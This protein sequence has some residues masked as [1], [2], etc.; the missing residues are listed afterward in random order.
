MK[1]IKHYNIMLVEDE[2]LLRQS[3]ARHIEALDSGY[4]VV[5]QVPD[6]CAA[7]EA[8]KSEDIHLIITDIRMP[9]MDGLTLAKN[10][11]ERYPH[12]LTIVLSGY[13]DFE[14]AQEALRQGVFDYLLKPV[15]REN[16]ENALSKASLLLEKH[17]QLE[18]DSSM[19]GKDSQEIVDYVVLYIRSHYM[20]DVDFSELSS[21]LG[22]SS[23]YL[24]KLFNKH[25]ASH[26]R[27]GG[28]GRI[29]RSVSFQQ[30]LPQTHRDESNS[31][32]S[33]SAGRELKPTPVIRDSFPAAGLFNVAG[34]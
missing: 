20:D 14:Y 5:C 18:E 27:S 30:D 7:L 4:K 12:I 26:P 10:V 17:F 3:L 6:G 25:H 23:A 11:H 9:V 28:K 31:L 15:S 22:F 33:G 19:T 2:F 8:L 1:K 32:P 29:S 13:A 16:L 21:R 34:L 24:T